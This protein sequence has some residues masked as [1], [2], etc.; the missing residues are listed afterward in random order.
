MAAAAGYFSYPSFGVLF[1]FVL[2][3]LPQVPLGIAISWGTIAVLRASDSQS[4][5]SSTGWAAL[6]AL[7]VAVLMA[8][9][10]PRLWLWALIAGVALGE[11]LSA[12]I[13]H[14]FGFRLAYP[15]LAAVAATA[16]L[17]FCTQ[18]VVQRGFA[19]RSVAQQDWLALGLSSGLLIGIWLHWLR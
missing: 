9:F 8:A 10:V 3:A 11:P 19:R 14:E 13:A 16:L 15:A 6:V 4:L 7:W 12:A 5:A 2:T 1:L 18:R 17:A